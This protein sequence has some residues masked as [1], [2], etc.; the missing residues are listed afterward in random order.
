MP[1][2]RDIYYCSFIEPAVRLA[3]FNNR[4]R[5]EPL[6]ASNRSRIANRPGG[7]DQAQSIESAAVRLGVSGSFHNPLA[8]DQRRQT[9]LGGSVV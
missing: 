3:G 4:S 5:M 8:T 9:P 1:P 7:E 2:P 6:I